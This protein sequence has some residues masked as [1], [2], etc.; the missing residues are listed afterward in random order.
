MT[1]E[2]AKKEIIDMANALQLIP[3]TPKGKAVSMALK[4]LEQAPCEDAISRQSAIF[5][6]SDLKQDLPDD[7][8][9]TDMVMAHNEGILEYQTQLSL[10][11]PVTPQQNTGHW[12]PV[13]ERLPEVNQRVLVTSYGRV[14]YAMMIS[15][16]ANSGH[17]V[18]KL[19]DSL[20]ERVVCETTVHN[21]FTTSRIK[22]WMPLPEPYKAESEG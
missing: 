5:L 14:C 16:D 21:E 1:G 9:I 18:F 3:N 2:E 4:V 19:Q 20:N 8:H 13:S 6:A 7:E 22:A 11:P 10:L 17:P 12:I 15:A